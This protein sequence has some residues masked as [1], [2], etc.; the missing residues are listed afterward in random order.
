[1]IFK[2][3]YQLAGWKFMSLEKLLLQYLIAR[4]SWTYLLTQLWSLTLRNL[5]THLDRKIWFGDTCHLG[6][7][8]ISTTFTSAFRTRKTFSALPLQPSFVLWGGV[9]G[10]RYFVLEMFRSIQPAPHARNW[11]LNCATREMLLP[12]RGQLT[13]WWDTC[14]VNSRTGRCTGDWGQRQR[15]IKISWS[16]FRIAWT[17]VST[18]YQSSLMEEFL[19]TSLPW[20]DLC[21]KWQRI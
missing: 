13:G 20:R 17:K 16:A 14:K 18:L 15:G 12:M 10:R 9:V 8:Q 7:G 6:T 4:N 19:S 11:K 3:C 2:L 21:W 1:M 5:C